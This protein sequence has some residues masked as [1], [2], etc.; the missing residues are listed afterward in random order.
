[1]RHTSYATAARPTGGRGLAHRTALADGLFQLAMENIYLQLT[2]QN[3]TPQWLRDYF[4]QLRNLVSGLKT[5]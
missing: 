5:T 1:L 2:E 4:V 3:Y